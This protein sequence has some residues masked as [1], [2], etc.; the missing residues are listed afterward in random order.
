M[1]ECSAL[2]ASRAHILGL[3][4]H[5]SFGRGSQHGSIPHLGRGEGVAQGERGAPGTRKAKSCGEPGASSAGRKRKGERDREVGAG[6]FSAAPRPG[7][8]HHRRGPSPAAGTPTP[9][10]RGPARRPP[11][12]PPS[13]APAPP[14]ALPPMPPAPRPPPCCR[15]GRGGAAAAAARP[16]A[17]RPGPASPQ[18]GSIP[19]GRPLAR[20][21]RQRG[22]SR[23]DPALPAPGLRERRAMAAGSAPAALGAAGSLCLASASPLGPPRCAGLGVEEAQDG[24][25]P[26]PRREGGVAARERR[27]EG[28]Q[29]GI[30]PLTASCSP[31]TPQQGGGDGFGLRQRLPWG[32]PGSELRSHASLRLINLSCT[33]TGSFSQVHEEMCCRERRATGF[34]KSIS[35]RGFAGWF[36]LNVYLLTSPQYTM[37]QL[38]ISLLC[39]GEFPSV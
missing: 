36:V 29:M 38:S 30:I 4:A 33:H 22:R 28:I 6:K 32:S 18:C 3:R 25:S 15:G 2:P 14:R 8:P 5:K 27:P 7:A 10:G 24:S 9:A 12:A 26:Q 37:F 39:F 35:F 13:P 17:L 23:S 31:I 1:R 11:P 34:I 21:P 19:Q 20:P 16:P